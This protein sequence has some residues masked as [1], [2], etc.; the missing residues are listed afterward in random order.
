M[1]LLS[2]GC[3]QI[4]DVASET[5]PIE[6][7]VSSDPET[8]DPRYATDAV[9]L[10]ATRL[11]HAGLVRLDPDK[12]EPLPYLARGWR[13]LDPLT[14]EVD[15]RD[16]VRFHSGA[17]LRPDDVVETLRAFASPSVGSRHARVVEA[18]AGA[19]VSG[20]HQ[21]TVTLGGSP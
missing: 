9:G 7:M 12:L 18:I 14:L 21:V 19:R 5:R 13:W 8:L 3:A 6:M 17:P 10:R 16:D 11:V 2:A 15:L 4:T 20:E 1:L